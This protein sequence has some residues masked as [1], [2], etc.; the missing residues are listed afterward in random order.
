MNTPQQEKHSGTVQTDESKEY[1]TGDLH[2]R[3]AMIYG[4]KMDVSPA[5]AAI[6]GVTLSFKM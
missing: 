4:Q 3:I 6:L 1:I 2:M 5:Y